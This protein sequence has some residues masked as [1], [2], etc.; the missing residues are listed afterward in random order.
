M[1]SED[2][3]RE[4]AAPSWVRHLV[5]PVDG[6]PASRQGLELAADVA[7]RTGSR[8]TVVHV[9]H[10]P[11]GISLS[12]AS[13]RGAIEVTLEEMEAGVRAAVADVLGEAGV[14]WNLVLR[15]GSP[16]EEILQ[17]VKDLGVD[18]VII[19][20]KPHGTVHDVLLG[21]TSVYLAKHSPVPV[22]IARSQPEDLAG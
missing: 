2:R 5:V 1:G 9:R 7:R 20:S 3:V 19:G 17:V 14:D 21:S 6:S 22:L 16:G 8:V 11:A 15:S 10:L 4:Q 18:L 13:T 12:P